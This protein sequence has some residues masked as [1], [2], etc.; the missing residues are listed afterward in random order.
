M[1]Q[2][3]KSSSNCRCS[4]ILKIKEFNKQFYVSILKNLDD[5]LNFIETNKLPTL[6]QEEIE[7]PNKLI[8][9]NENESIINPS[10]TLHTIQDPSFSKHP[11]S[12]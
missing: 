10:N 6:T 8:T 5:M 4:R 3:G 7:T 12:R 1:R 11:R 2:K 9:I